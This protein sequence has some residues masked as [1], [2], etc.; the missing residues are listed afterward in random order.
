MVREQL[1]FATHAVDNE[2]RMEKAAV[3]DIFGAAPVIR[4]F[5][6]HVNS[7]D[8]EQRDAGSG[9]GVSKVEAFCVRTDES[10]PDQTS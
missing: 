1:D 8:F 5:M 2:T 7:I 3:R 9:K 10:E 4:M 6:R